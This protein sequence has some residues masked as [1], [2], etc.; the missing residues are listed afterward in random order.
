MAQIDLGEFLTKASHPNLGK[1]S[2]VGGTTG[3]STVKD[4]IV[5]D[6]P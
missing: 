5:Y 6:S 1:P 4:R 2:T 3:E